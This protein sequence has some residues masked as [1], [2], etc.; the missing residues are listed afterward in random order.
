ME[1][2]ALDQL[3][4]TLYFEK[5]PNG[6]SVYLLPKPALTKLMRHLPPDM[7]QS[8][9]TFKPQARSKPCSGRNCPFFRAQNV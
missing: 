2:I 3:Q 5:L 9:I 6:L 8:T 7:A 4:E 1:Q